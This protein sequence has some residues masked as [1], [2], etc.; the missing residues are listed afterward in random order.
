M[1][2]PINDLFD[3]KNKVIVLTGSA[4][5]LGT[6]FAH[7]LSSAG[8]N[9]VLVDIDCNKNKKL[10]KTLSKKYHTH[11]KSYCVDVSNPAEIKKLKSEILKKFKKIDG[12][13]NNAF[14]NHTVIQS[15]SGSKKLEHFPFEDWEQS[16]RTNLTSVFLCC[17]EFGSV[18]EN[19][20]NGVI[21][22]ISSIYG[23][24]GPDQRI[25]GNSKINAPISYAATKGS[26]VNLT[27][28]LATYWYNKNIRVNTLSL[29]GVENK[30]YQSKEFIK[31]YSEKTTLGKM[32][33]KSD[34]NG[35]ILFLLSNA[36]SYM[37][38]SNLII[39]GG[40]TAW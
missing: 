21:V 34:Y 23:L 28:Y 36:S 4:G 18:M 32:A 14:L 39:D 16:I 27:K 2:Y 9:I 7:T 8:A 1:K 26:I 19:Q 25:Y 11:S 13:I 31:K 40:W 6:E 38:G 24:V 33:K 20:R 10:E 35:A 3:L 37:T 15:E 17:K 12:L 30:K 29:G 5:V 22:N